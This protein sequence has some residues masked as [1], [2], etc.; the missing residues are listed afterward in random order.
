MEALFW[1]L[2]AIA[3]Y[4]YFGYPLLLKLLPGTVAPVKQGREDEWPSVTMLISAYNEASCIQEKIDNSLAL[5]YPTEKLKIIVIS[6]ASDDGTDAIVDAVPDGRVSLLRMEERGGKT[7]GLNAGVAAS[8]ADVVVFSDA[9]AMYATNSVAALVAAFADPRVGAVI[10]E[11]TYRDPDTESGKSESLYWRYETQIKRLESNSGS[12]VGGDGAIYAIRRSLYQPMRPGDL[13]DFVNPLQVVQAGKLCVYEP[14]AIS[15]EAAADSF[16]GE[17]R[18]KVRIVNRAWR[19]LWK[20]RSMLNPL[21]YG[22]FSLKLWSHKVLRWLMPLFMLILLI[23]NVLIAIDDSRY[24]A[25]LIGQLLFYALALFG[26]NWRDRAKQPT[27]TRIPYYFC[28]VNFAAAAGLVEVFR[29]K[30]YTTWVT[31]RD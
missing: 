11:S 10:G 30:S 16:K 8:D 20:M 31:V 12:V 7:A 5:D 26:Y 23:S 25:L 24:Y 22:V 27:I 21:A 6:D 4:V 17:F 14:E 18:R 9:N 3:A 28:L 1:G 15:Y 2:A 13:S 19:A 29:G